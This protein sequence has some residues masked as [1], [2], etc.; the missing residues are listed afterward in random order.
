[1]CHCL[2]TTADK[3]LLLHI[4]DIQAP[5]V[6]RGHAL[7]EGSQASSGSEPIGEPGQVTVTVQVVGVE[8]AENRWRQRDKFS[9]AGMKSQSSRTWL[10]HPKRPLWVEFQINPA[11]ISAGSVNASESALKYSKF[12]I[13]HS[14]HQS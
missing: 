4:W 2:L 7:G 10:S 8:A 9:R 11:N 3:I 14:L 5:H 1:M 13:S 12:N 6:G